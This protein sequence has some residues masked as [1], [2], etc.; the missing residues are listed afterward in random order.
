LEE[1]ADQ[2]A[3]LVPAGHR[4]VNTRLRARFGEAG[5]AAEQIGGVSYLFFLRRLVDAVEQDWPGVLE[6]LETIHRILVTRQGLFSN[7][8]L[9]STNWSQFRSDF[10]QFVASLP[11]S[12]ASQAAWSPAPMV[13]FEGLSIPAQ[14]NYVGKGANLYNIGYQLDGSVEVILN[15]LRSTYIW[16]KVRVQGGA[17]GGFCVFDP[18]SGGFSFLSY[19]DPNLVNTLDIY[20]EAGAFF[21]NNEAS[22]LTE[23]E[24][25]K[26]IIGT[27][28]D[29]DAYQ[30][31]DAKGFTSMQRYLLGENDEFRQ[32]IRDEVLSASFKDFQ[33]FGLVLDKLAQAGQVV[34]LGSPEALRAA[35]EQ[36]GDLLAIEKVL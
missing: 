20:D 28:G 21:R 1:K 13:K 24:L 15:Y 18:R 34:V 11:N 23:E 6:K 4:V 19:R 32:Q 5:W 29:M 35:N 8:T 2:E 36:K 31:P 16:E 27:I 33:A 17:Y 25:T 10:L 30:L 22:R 12:V 7:I 9:D 3:G 14:V 26:S